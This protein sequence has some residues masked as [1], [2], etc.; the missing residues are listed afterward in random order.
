M[1][2]L[3]KWLQEGDCHIVCMDANKDIYKKLLGR[4]LTDRDGLNMSE[5]VGDFTGKQVGPT[6]FW[7]SN[8]INRVW[9]TCDVVVAHACVMP[10]GYGVGNHRMFVVDFLEESLI[11]KAPYCIKHFTSHHLNT[12]I[13]SRATQ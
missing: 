3:E 2:Q 1:R 8:P 10:A 7:G 5:V 13:S 9:A 4:S 12:K 6:F 11:G